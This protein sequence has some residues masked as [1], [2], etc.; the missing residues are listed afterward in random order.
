M[1][2]DNLLER[3]ANH[4]I[5]N[6]SFLPDLGL[7]HGKMGIVIFFAHYARYTGETLYDD[8]AGE[9]LDEIY[10]EIHDK[11]SI[12]FESGLCGIGWGIEYLL[13][14]DFIEGDSDDI[15]SEIDM[16]IMERDLRRIKDLSF[17]TGLEGVSCYILKRINSSYRKKN[18]TPFDD[19]YLSDWRMI[20]KYL[21]IKN[22]KIELL[23]LLLDIPEGENFLAWELSLDKGC[24]GCGLK[25]ILS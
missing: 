23:S 4:L 5:M 11:I 1:D 2:K 3:I 7:Y 20:I 24:A 6:A 10:E 13:E 19:I 15:L 18:I 21:D 9:L 8:F 17:R 22:K 12:Y 14:N 25:K 16:K